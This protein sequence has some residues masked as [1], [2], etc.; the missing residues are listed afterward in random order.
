MV[1]LERLMTIS[2][3]DWA[4]ELAGGNGER[5]YNSA[6]LLAYYFL[7]LDGEGDGANLVEFLKEITKGTRADGSTEAQA[8]FLLRNRDYEKLEADLAQAWRSEGLKVE[9]N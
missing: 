5:Y 2:H 7:R 9:F 6:N 1:G 8:T 4:A 3:E